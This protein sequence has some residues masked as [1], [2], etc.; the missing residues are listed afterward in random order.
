MKT[1]LA[2]NKQKIKKILIFF[3]LIFSCSVSTVFVIIS[4]TKKPFQPSFWNYKSYISYQNKNIINKNF[5]YKEFA[6]ISEFS[7]ALINNKAFAGI[8]S[9]FQIV[10]LIKKD[11]LQEIDFQKLF[12]FQKPFENDQQLKNLLQNLYTPSVWKHLISYDEEL[13]TN[14]NGILFDKPKHLW[15][16]MIPYFVQDIVFGINLDKLKNQ[17][18]RNLY[19][20]FESTDKL[21]TNNLI[22]LNSNNENKQYQKYSFFNILNTLFKNGIEHLT[23]TDA[24]RNNLLIGSSYWKKSNQFTQ[25]NIN[26]F[27]TKVTKENYKELI[28]NFAFLIEDATNHKITDTNFINLNPDGLK[29]LTELIMPKNSGGNPSDATIMFNGDALD[30]W[31]SSDNTNGEVQDGTIRII[32]PQNNLLLV[33][34]FVISKSISKNNQ[35]N[36]YKTLRKSIL[37]K[38]ETYWNEY[39]KLFSKSYEFNLNKKKETLNQ[40]SLNL[41]SEYLNSIFKD[42]S[43]NEFS[44]KENLIFKN[45]IINDLKVIYLRT[46]NNKKIFFNLKDNY[47]NYWKNL[48]KI[49][50]EILIALVNDF[51]LRNNTNEL[52]INKFNLNENSEEFL[53][54]LINIISHVNFNDKRY[55]NEILKNKYPYLENFDFVNYT[56]A[57]SFDFQFI[58]RNYFIDENND[59]DKYALNIFNISSDSSFSSI[60]HQ[61]ISSTNDKLISL[62]N[63][64]YLKKVKK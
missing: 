50:K 21:L 57:F 39:E 32:R 36:L 24:T 8:G 9:D 18:Q 11:I 56:P 61:K 26:K 6:E 7:N 54:Q 23:I 20:T 51:N 64:Y 47:L 59:V 42:V 46:L 55:F 38:R 49:N 29:L 30:A 10:S 25:D 33:D 44:R 60:N 31:Y 12:N 19:D 53:L 41:Y 13:K 52:K 1:I 34:G 43:L 4:K 14:E 3:L 62:I 45:Q 16:Y 40:M 17:S 27:G 15:K 35:D 58:K 37:G 22:D 48:N 5:E 63:D 2:K 28:D